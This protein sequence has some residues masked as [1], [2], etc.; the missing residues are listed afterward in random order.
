MMATKTCPFFDPDDDE[1]C[2]L[3]LC[4]YYKLEREIGMYGSIDIYGFCE[5]GASD[6]DFDKC[7][8]E[9]NMPWE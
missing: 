6:K 2:S 5:L 1:S 7:E 8:V 4:S 9:P 3:G